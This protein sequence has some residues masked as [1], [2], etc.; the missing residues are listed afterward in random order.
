MRSPRSPEISSLTTEYEIAV[1]QKRIAELE[2]QLAI[3]K[4]KLERYAWLS[5]RIAKLE[6]LSLLRINQR[7]LTP[8]DQLTEY[9]NLDKQQLDSLEAIAKSTIQEIKRW[10]TEQAKVVNSN[11]NL[12]IFECPPPPPSILENYYRNLEVILGEED[13]RL[14]M[15]ILRSAATR[16]W[17]MQQRIE[18]KLGPGNIGELSRE[19]FD[20]T[21]NRVGDKQ[22][23]RSSDI[24][25]TS[26]AKRWSHLFEIVPIEANNHQIP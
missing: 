6:S 15:P 24:E 8:F 4:P 12:F 10:E 7:S 18:I 26:F 11:D 5:E 23:T 9:L 13:A 17:G 19:V 20:E 2:E 14:V 21:G 25:N 16:E 22:A 1:L 3:A